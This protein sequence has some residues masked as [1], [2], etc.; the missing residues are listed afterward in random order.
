[1]GF[2]VFEEG[3]GLAVGGFFVHVGDG[4]FCLCFRVTI[5]IYEAHAGRE[6]GL[7]DWWPS[8]GVVVE[9]P[10]KSEDTKEKDDC[11]ERNLG[12]CQ[13][14]YESVIWIMTDLRVRREPMKVVS[15]GQSR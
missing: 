12:R 5:V 7:S 8:C 1:M 15:F 4:G 13:Q 11:A 14:S 2:A 6:R 3:G 10:G 9:P